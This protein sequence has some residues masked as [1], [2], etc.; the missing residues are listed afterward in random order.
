M[1]TQLLT[2]LLPTS[3]QIQRKLKPPTPQNSDNNGSSPSTEASKP[4]LG[5]EEN[6]AAHSPVARRDPLD[7]CNTFWEGLWHLPH[8]YACSTCAKEGQKVFFL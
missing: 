4:G 1:G 6:L 7:S 2:C 3:F 8:P 5:V